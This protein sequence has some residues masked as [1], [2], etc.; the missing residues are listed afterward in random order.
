MHDEGKREKTIATS[1]SHP[2]Q[3]GF[4]VASSPFFLSTN[5]ENEQQVNDSFCGEDIYSTQKCLAQ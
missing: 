5:P 1:Q 3:Q 2:I 4:C